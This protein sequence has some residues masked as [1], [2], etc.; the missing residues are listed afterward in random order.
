MIGRLNS[1]AIER[2]RERYGLDLTRD[3]LEEMAGLIAAGEA[4]RLR[5]ERDRRFEVYW[6]RF[7]G[8]LLVVS[9]EPVVGRVVSFL[10]PDSV[11]VGSYA[12]YRA[13]RRSTARKRA[14][15]RKWI[16]AQAP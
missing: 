12:R 10:P 14:S 16:R 8:R 2:A 3:D 5:V 9:Y 11:K 6:L 7:K 13:K 4:V 15:Q 1:H